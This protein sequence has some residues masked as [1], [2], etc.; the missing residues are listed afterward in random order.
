VNYSTDYAFGGSGGFQTGSS[1]KA[2]D[3]VAW[4]QAG[5]TLNETE[6]ASRHTFSYSDF[7][8][9][10]TGL[11]GKPW[12]VTNDESNETGTMSVLKATAD[13]VNTA[14]AD[15]ATQLDLCNISD[16]AK[17]LGAHTASPSEAWQLLPSM[18]L[19]INTMSP[20][21]MAT[22]YAGIANGGK[23]CTPIAI[24]RVVTADGK[25]H[26]VPASTCT[27]AITPEIAAGVSYALQGVMTHGTATTA[28]PHDGTQLMGKTGTTDNSE[29]NWLVT[30]STTITN[31]LWVGNVS[32]HVALRRQSFLGVGGGN[33]KFSIAKPILSALDS[34]F[35]GGTFTAPPSSMLG[36]GSSSS[37]ESGSSTPAPGAT[38]D[39][40]NTTTPTPGPGT[41]Q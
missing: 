7:P 18:I 29:Q 14:F 17:S 33:V 25:N 4:L 20:L 1:F 28:N 9:S 35:P 27:Q 10:C 40:G 13:S 37:D 6:N 19:G 34:A 15:M 39:P 22:A 12:N 24:D 11:G 3:L 31:A 23:V 30:S 5:H 36:S 21:T 16:A 41:N 32:G 38:T 2:F 8:A 26:A